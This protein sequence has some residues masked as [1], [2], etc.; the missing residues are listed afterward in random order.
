MTLSYYTVLFSVT[1][2]FI[3][4]IQVIYSG[5]NMSKKCNLYCIQKQ[6]CLNKLPFSNYFR[7]RVE[8]ERLFINI[9]SHVSFSVAVL[10]KKDYSSTFAAM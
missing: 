1:L 9:C 10:N 6:Y 4:P 2:K 5:A 7:G 8:Q 3:Y